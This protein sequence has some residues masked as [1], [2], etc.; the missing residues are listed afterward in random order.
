MNKHTLAAALSAAVL[1]LAASAANAGVV[2]SIGG[3]G[4]ANQGQTSAFSGQAGY[5]T[6]DFESAPLAPAALQ[7]PYSGNG[8]IVT[9][10]VGGQYAAPQTAANQ[11]TSRYLAV[12]TQNTGNRTVSIDAPTLSSYFGIW[13]GSVDNYNT[14]TFFNGNTQVASFDGAA[15]RNVPNP[16]L[17]PGN[18]SEAA[19]FNFTFDGGDVFTRVVL[20]STGFALESDNHVFGTAVVPVPGAAV[21]LMSGMLGMLFAARRQRKGLQVA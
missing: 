16:F 18:Q 21:L 9:G 19:Y 11:N 3:V 6:F 17:T 14:I 4:I 8:R 1:G 10:S 13:W 20:G 7:A 5:T 2:I 12:P 15:L